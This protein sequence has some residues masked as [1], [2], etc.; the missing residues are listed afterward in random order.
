MKKVN[1]LISSHVHGLFDK[2]YL[3]VSNTDVPRLN[4]NVATINEL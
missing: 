3:Q 4:I 2:R 1:D